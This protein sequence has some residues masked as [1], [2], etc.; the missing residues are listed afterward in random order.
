MML[1]WVFF[2]SAVPQARKASLAR[3]LEKRKERYNLRVHIH[4][5]LSVLEQVMFPYSGLVMYHSLH[6]C[7]QADIHVCM[8][9]L[10]SDYCCAVFIIQE[11]DGEQ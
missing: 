5:S 10:Q 3:F 1:T 11:P 9:V 8:L 4:Y 2:V 6:L 7:C